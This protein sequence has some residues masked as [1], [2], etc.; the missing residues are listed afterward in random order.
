MML[1]HL[2]SQIDKHT[3]NKNESLSVEILKPN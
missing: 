1:I 2:F 3:K